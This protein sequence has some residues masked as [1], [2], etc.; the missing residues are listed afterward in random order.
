M[1]TTLTIEGQLFG[2]GRA[3]FPDLSRPAPPEWDT[4]DTPL[5]LRDLISEIVREQVTAFRERREDR[6]FLHALT[7]AQIETAAARGK[8]DLGGR[9]EDE[10]DADPDAAVANALLAFEDGLYYVFV[11]NEHRTS[12]DDT[13][14]LRAESRVTF[15]RLVALAG[16]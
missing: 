16:G 1:P 6:R 15:L 8:V 7:A 9:T 12:L 14:T 13:I 2:R 5:T 10:P 3:L 11:D 4:R